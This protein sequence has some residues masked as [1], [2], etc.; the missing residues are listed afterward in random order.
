VLD[1]PEVLASRLAQYKDLMLHEP[2]G[3]NGLPANPAVVRRYLMTNRAGYTAA[4][5]R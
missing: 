5:G 3:S 2:L 1:S 4:A